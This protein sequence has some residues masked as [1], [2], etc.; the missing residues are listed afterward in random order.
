MATIERNDEGDFDLVCG[1]CGFTARMH[2]GESVVPQVEI[3]LAQHAC[4]RA[5]RDEPPR[6]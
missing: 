1:R 5:G 4:D 6:P 3:F 2:P